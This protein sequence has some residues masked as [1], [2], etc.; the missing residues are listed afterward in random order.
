MLAKHGFDTVKVWKIALDEEPEEWVSEAIGKGRL[1]WRETP[2]KKEKYLQGRLA[3]LTGPFSIGY[4][5][6]WLVCQH[7]DYL[8]LSEK[9]FLKEYTLEEN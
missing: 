8:I 3:P 7:D 5:G 1:L 2:I 4:P 6:S 9:N